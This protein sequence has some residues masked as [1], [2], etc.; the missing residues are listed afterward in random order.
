MD[1]HGT[2][3]PVKS[4][5]VP[6]E[7]P[8]AGSG[9]ESLASVPPTGDTDSPPADVE[10]PGEPVSAH[11]P[12]ADGTDDAGTDDDGTDEASQAPADDGTDDAGHAP[13]DDGTDDA[14]Q[15]PADDGTDDDGT[16]DAG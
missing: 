6:D 7:E 8:P 13:A 3:V 15:A 12:T 11:L 5:A 10:Q 14:G 9:E 1:E 4:A 16:D 2:D